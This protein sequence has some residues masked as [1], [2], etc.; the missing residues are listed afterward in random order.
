MA[1]DAPPILPEVRLVRPGDCLRLCRCGGSSALP[2]CNRACAEALRLTLVREQRLL[3]CR[4]GR[5]ADL[6]YCDGSH[7]PPAP[8]LGDKWRRFVGKV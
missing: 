3:L 4:C 6:P 5:S 7:S 8:G 2:D 1:D